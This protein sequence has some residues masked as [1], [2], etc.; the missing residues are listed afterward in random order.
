MVRPSYDSAL[1]ENLQ[2]YLKSWGPINWRS[3]VDHPKP[4]PDETVG[5][6]LG[7]LASIED[8]AF[9]MQVKIRYTGAAKLAA[10]RDFN[11]IWLAEESE[12]ARALA[13]LAARFGDGGMPRSRPHGVWF[14]DRQSLLIKPFLWCRGFNRTGMLAGYLT[15]GALQEFV[16]LTTYNAIA[17]RVD[18]APTLDILQQIARQ[19]A[20]HMRFYRR[21][22]EAVLMGSASAQR[23]VR[24]ALR[25]Y[26]RPPGID[27]L[28]YETWFATFS[29]LLADPSLRRAYLRTDGICAALPGI[30]DLG[31]MRSFL[32]RY[33]QHVKVAPARR[34]APVS[35]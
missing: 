33:D 18:D 12:H 28:G 15:L 13:A 31:I 5:R 26:W 16:A 29:P 32:T 8:D 35:V 20:R 14:R 22:A 17:R 9:Y 30:G 4:A 25:R 7:A 27:L 19:E 2:S 34:V 3:I 23:F 10:I 21:G 6:L 1:E 11:A 24:F